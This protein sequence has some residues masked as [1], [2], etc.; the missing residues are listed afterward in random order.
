MDMAQ[1]FAYIFPENVQVLSPMAHLIKSE[2][3][4]WN[5]L[6][7]L[8]PKIRGELSSSETVRRKMKQQILSQKV[9]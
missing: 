9:T 3:K 2:S 4:F 1:F 8:H 5:W 7:A 6:N